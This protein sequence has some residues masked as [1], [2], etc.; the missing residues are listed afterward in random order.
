MPIVLLK[1]DRVATCHL[2]SVNA[3]GIRVQSGSRLLFSRESDPSPGLGSER[4]SRKGAGVALEV[5]RVDASGRT[6]S[7]KQQARSLEWF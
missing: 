4:Q 2:I 7:G 3:R 1:S 5:A 6:K